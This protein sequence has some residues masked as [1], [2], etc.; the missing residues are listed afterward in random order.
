MQMT[1]SLKRLMRD[2]SVSQKSVAAAAIV[3][4]LLATAAFLTWVTQPS[5]TVL[6]SG[7][8][9]TQLSQ[10]V[11]SLEASGIPYRL[12]GG[13]SRVLV[14]QDSVYRVRADLASDGIQGSVVPKGYELL[15]EQGLS[16]SDFRQRV[17]YQRAL[18]GEL[19]RTLGAMGAISAATV[20][21]VI[22]EEA[23]F[24]ENQEPVTASVLIDAA[25]RGHASPRD[26]AF[27]ASLV[28]RQYW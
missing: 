1:E 24:V 4:A 28:P 25:S 21:L 10:V 22:P 12:E 9:E 2:M 23:L 27:S 26:R 15:D 20:H 17:D 5:Y 7:I 13:G 16:V 19:S 11:D 8:D 3:V 14:P 18:E 6:Y